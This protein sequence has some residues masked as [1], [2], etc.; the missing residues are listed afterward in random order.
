AMT[1]GRRVAVLLNRRAQGVTPARLRWFAGQVAAEDLFVTDSLPSG[2]Q[3]VRAILAA[4]HDVVCPGGGDGTFMETAAALLRLAPAGA[5][6]PALLPLRLGTGNAVHDVCG[7]SPPTARGLARDL[8]RAADPAEAPSPLRLLDVDGRLT[9]FAG[10]GLDADW[11]A[12]Y[13]RVIKRRFNDSRLLPLARGAPGYVA[14]AFGVT[15]PRLVRRPYI[16]VRIVAVGAALRLD[17]RGRTAAELPDG[18]VLFEGPATLAAASTV[19][20]YSAGFR[21]FPHVDAIGERFELKV[22]AARLGDVVRTAVHMLTGRQ[23]AEGGA[24]R[25]LAARA[26]RVELAAPARYHLGGDVQPPARA[27]TIRLGPRPVPV[28]RP[29]SA[30]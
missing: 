1:G 14:T 26:V 29:R 6:L 8:A 12:D 10:V 22:G 28:L 25:D 17:A 15:I 16:D 27:F 11:Q 7:A 13:A 9:Q 2:E 5:P 4:G 18:A 19:P 20:S 24:V 23:A 21:F 30:R 3:A